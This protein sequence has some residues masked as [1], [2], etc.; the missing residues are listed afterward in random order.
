MSASGS[1]DKR[2]DVASAGWKIHPGQA[3]DRTVL[4][5]RQRLR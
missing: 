3:L 2:S 5:L 4:L 1:N